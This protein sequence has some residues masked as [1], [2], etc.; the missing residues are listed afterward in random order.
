MSFLKEILS[1]TRG[2]HRRPP[3]GSKEEVSPG[4]PHPAYWGKWPGGAA[5]IRPDRWVVIG[6]ENTFARWQCKTPLPELPCISWG[7]LKVFFLP[8]APGDLSR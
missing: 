5:D 8:W 2:F 3:L 6:F 7:S 4:K 1:P